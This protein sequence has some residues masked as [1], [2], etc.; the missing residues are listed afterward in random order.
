MREVI[1]RMSLKAPRHDLAYWLSR[2]IEKLFAA[3]EA[4]L[5]QALAAAR[6]HDAE[7]GLQRVYRVTQLRRL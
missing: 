1:R 2:P 4:L 6:G 7:Q 3:V 5:Q